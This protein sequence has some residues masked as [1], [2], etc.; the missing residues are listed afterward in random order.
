MSKELVLGFKDMD[1]G[2]RITN[3]VNWVLE[4]SGDFLH[5]WYIDG[6]VQRPF[7]NILLD[8]YRDVFDAWN[9]SVDISGGNAEHRLKLDMSVGEIK[10]SLEYISDVTGNIIRNSYIVVDPDLLSYIVEAM[11]YSEGDMYNDFGHL[12][13]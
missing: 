5:A 8:D 9:R 13:S 10:L 7:Y 11:Y 1:D 3:I 2:E 4:D 6:K 12:A